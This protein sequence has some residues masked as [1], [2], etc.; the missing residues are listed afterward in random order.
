MKTGSVRAEFRKLRADWLS[1]D[2]GAMVS[3]G[4]VLRALSAA[5]D[6]WEHLYQVI[7]HDGLHQKTMAVI[8]A[9]QL[10]SSSSRCRF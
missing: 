6:A 2:D 10:M 1:H 5:C 4:E 7:L 3:T 9:L 8:A